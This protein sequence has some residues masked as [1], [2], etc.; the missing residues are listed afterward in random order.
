[1]INFI[2]KEW[3]VENFISEI[4]FGVVLL[5]LI[6]LFWQYI[7]DAYRA[8]KVYKIIATHNNATRTRRK[9]SHALDRFMDIY[10][11]KGPVSSRS[12]AVYGHSEAG[13]FLSEQY[14]DKG[15]LEHHGLVVTKEGIHGTTAEAVRSR[16]T[17]WVYG[18]ARWVTERERRKTDIIITDKSG[19]FRKL[20][21]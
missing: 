20:S 5:G 4:V 8:I 9:G 15:I 19:K 14:V 2:T 10:E 11:S 12:T 3:I 16:F 7:K 6:V 21:N 17:R 18:I 13:G 1:M